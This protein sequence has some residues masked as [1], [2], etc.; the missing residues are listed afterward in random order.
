MNAIRLRNYRCFEDTGLIELKR[1]NLL[2]GANSSGKSSFLKFFP[3]LKQSL[4]IK[5]NGVFRWLGNDVD[6]KDFRNTVQEGKDAI[7]IEYKVDNFYQYSRL[8]NTRLLNNRKMIPDVHVS[9]SIVPLHEHF[10]MI[11]N[12]HIEYAATTIDVKFEEN[13]K[14]SL[15][16]NRLSTDNTKGLQIIAQ[17]NDA[18]F[19]RLLF[20]YKGDEKHGWM[21]SPVF[22]RQKILSEVQKL[23]GRFSEGHRFLLFDTYPISFDNFKKGLNGMSDKEVPN[24]IAQH[25]YD[26]C[27][28]YN[29]NSLI[30]SLNINLLKVASN[31]VYIKPIRATIERYYRFQNLD[32]D[33]IDADG[34]NL[35]MFLYNLEEKAFEAFNDW[36]SMHFSFKVYIKSSDGH[37]ELFVSE[38]GKTPRNT[39]DLG[40]GYTQLLPILAVIWRAVFLE[41]NSIRTEVSQENHII[42]IEQPELHLHPIFQGKFAEMLSIITRLGHDRKLNV[43]FII[44]THSE[45][46]LNKLGDYVESRILYPEDISVLMLEQDKTGRSKITP[47]EYTKDGFLKEWPQNFMEDVVADR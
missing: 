7:Y 19:P 43:R 23:G 6:F 14:V 2:V 33:D 22:L 24:L 31:V 15:S 38:E 1:I 36:L 42:V 28:M 18:I 13:D 8:F 3:L 41:A 25:L 40:F 44:E 16:V 9:F 47:T 21:T 12:I 17:N 10:D 26:M 37:I 11:E 34:A 46:I 32:M 39:V 5:L 4:N 45:T 29:I 35:P 27:V 20:M 30:D